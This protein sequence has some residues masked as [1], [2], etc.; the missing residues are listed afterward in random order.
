MR[1]QG[2][3]GCQKFWKFVLKTNLLVSSANI[4]L[5]V[6]KLSKYG[7]KQCFFRSFFAFLAFFQFLLNISASNC[8]NLIWHE[9]FD[10]LTPLT[11]LGARPQCLKRKLTA[12]D[13]VILGIKMSFF[14][15]PKDHFLKFW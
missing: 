2:C 11:P 12:S 15:L 4:W 3:P 13:T 9:N 10:L 6:S 5:K 7:Q 8:Q 14:Y 1:S